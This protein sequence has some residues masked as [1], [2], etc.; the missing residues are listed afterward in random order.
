VVPR[1]DFQ[2]SC[3]ASRADSKQGGKV[4]FEGLLRLNHWRIN[5][6]QDRTDINITA[7]KLEKL[8]AIGKNR[9]KPAPRRL[10]SEKPLESQGRETI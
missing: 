10:E 2:R 9:P 1:Y 3:S 5:D 4:Y 6:G 8:G 7:W